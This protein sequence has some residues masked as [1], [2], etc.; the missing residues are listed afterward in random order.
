MIISCLLL[1]DVERLKKQLSFKVQAY[2]VLT[3]DEH[4]R[5]QARGRAHEQRASAPHSRRTAYGRHAHDDNAY[6]YA[7]GGGYGYGQYAGKCEP[8]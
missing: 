3:H 6:G 1:A 7:H 8:S 5:A 2:R 4:L